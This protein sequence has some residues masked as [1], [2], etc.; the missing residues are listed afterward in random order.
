MIIS[1]N[2]TAVSTLTPKNKP[3]VPPIL[4]NKATTTIAADSVVTVYDKES[5]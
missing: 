5:Y 4:D 2:S 1:I 3:S